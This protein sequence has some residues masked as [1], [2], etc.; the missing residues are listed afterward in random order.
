M[1]FCS[2]K[3]KNFNISDQDGNNEQYMVVA[4]LGIGIVA[5]NVAMLVS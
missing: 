3:H 4:S 2:D 1:Y 5:G